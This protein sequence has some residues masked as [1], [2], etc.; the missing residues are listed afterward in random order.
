M[1]VLHLNTLDEGGAWSAAYRLHRN[2]KSAGCNSKIL[3]ANKTIADS[4]IISIPYFLSKLLKF[5]RLFFN[6]YGK[7]LRHSKYF[8][9]NGGNPFVTTSIILKLIPFK[10]DI[11]IT[12]WVSNFITTRHLYELNK[13]TGAPIIWHLLDMG[14]LTGGCHYAFDC[15]GY[16]KRCGNCPAINSKK[17]NDLS[18][19]QWKEREKYLQKTDVTLV[20]PT[21]WLTKQA[22]QSSIFSGKRIEQIMLA[23]ETDIFCPAPKDVAR[24]VLNLPV[25]KKIIFFGARFVHEDRKGL[26]YLIEALHILNGLFENKPEI[27]ENIFIIVAGEK[28][29]EKELKIPFSHK[30]LGLI[31]DDRTLALAYQAA[32]IFVCSSIEDSG[33]MMIN[34]SILCGTPVVSFDMGVAPDLV[35]SG[36][37]GYRAKLKDSL[38]MAYGIK[39]ILELN[40]EE[41]Q[42]MSNNCTNLGLK[43]C[44][45][46]VQ[47]ND[48]IKL[49][50]SLIAVENGKN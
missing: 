14:P 33:P 49:F 48:F 17:M 13:V 20:S 4:D 3:V 46:N 39:F 25:D 44:D 16:T 43:K 12:H 9:R 18:H 36:K 38:D 15:L 31:N 1:N 23:L 34:E 6:V 8:Y 30:Y 29:E 27:K 2:L 22:Y 40:K 28:N 50:D 47:S 5:E 35:H 32:D 26:N 11:I 37:T 10:P 42:Q 19:R 24:D 45:P 21:S 41:M 7:S